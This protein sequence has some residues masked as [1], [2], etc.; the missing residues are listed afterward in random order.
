MKEKQLEEFA[1]ELRREIQGEVLIDPISRLLYSTD[2]SIYQITPLGVV[3]PKS[4]SDID[5]IVELAARHALPILAR[6]SGSSLSGQAVGPAIIVDCSRYLNKII[7]MNPEERTATVEPGVVLAVFNRQ[8]NAFGM[9]FG[10]DPASNDRATF[11]GMIGN[12]STGA[13]SILY[14]MTGDHVLELDLVLADGSS[15][16]AHDNSLAKSKQIAKRNSVEGRLYQTVL[17]IREK[18][19]EDVRVGWPKTW[20]RSTGYSLHYIWSWSPSKPPRWYDPNLPYPPFNRENL[21]L[22]PLIA[23]SE[24]TL[25]VIKS[26]KV[27]IV[28]APR[29]TVLAVLSYPSNYAACSD[30][31]QLLSLNPSAI[32]LIPRALIRLA[33][34]VP[35][36]ARRLGFVKGDPE[37]LLL[38]EFFGE[39]TTDVNDK[40]KAL[41]KDAIV[42]AEPKEQE[43]I[44]EVRK[45]GL[46]LL[47][48]RPGDWK[49]IPFVEDIAVPV[50]RL[51]EFVQAMDDI[52]ADNET[53]GDYYAHASAGCLHVRPLINL[54]TNEGTQRLRSI[55]EAAVVLTQ[56][57]DGA[58]SGEHGDGLARS[59][60]LNWV[61]DK[62]LVKAFRELKFAAD[63]ENVLNPG[64]KVDAE[65][66]DRNLRYGDTY[67]AEAWETKLDFSSQGGFIGAIEMCNGAGVCRKDDG[68]MC[69]TFQV[70]REEN[71]STRGRANLLRALISGR[72]SDESERMEYVKN[73][74]DLCIACKGCKAECPSA[75]DMAKLKSEFLDHYYEMRSRPFKDFVFARIG[76]MTARMRPIAAVLMP[77]VN[78][79][80]FNGIIRTLLGVHTQRAL[81]EVEPVIRSKQR[82]VK[83]KR[84]RA[85]FLPDAYSSV[86]Q[87][88]LLEMLSAIIGQIGCE[89][90]A[91][92]ISGAGRTLIS[93]G[94]LSKARNH[95]R[96]VIGAI[97]ELDPKGELPI[98]G[99]EPS[100]ILTLRDEYLDFF[101][102]DEYVKNLA[103][104]AWT[105]E[106]FIIRPNVD[107]DVR[108]DLLNFD[109]KPD[110]GELSD[111]R[112]RVLLHGHCYQKAQPPSDDGYPSGVSATV[113]MLESAGWRVELIDAGCCG[114]AGSFGYEDEHYEMSMQIAEM[115]LLPAV[116]EAQD[117]DQIAAAGFSCRSQIA[118]GTDRDPVHPLQLIDPSS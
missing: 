61:F 38:V 58:L 52:F 74:L 48:S 68:V 49:P 41:A 47:M 96:A 88:N 7:D 70:T 78:R 83:K 23:G 56:R 81:P 4:Q 44:W 99:I 69:P 3:Y 77:I 75:V 36:Y 105:I 63:P 108:I 37:T 72:L 110:M 94:Y 54:K 60:W 89:L 103:K 79:S 1:F 80:V 98:I 57:M 85:L 118:N 25:G 97:R 109:Q 102:R 87:P 111:Q 115:S 106:E 35:A 66:M 114:M 71:L 21:N 112:Q 28:D 19:W 32:E 24:G 8:A 84:E 15:M 82:A 76:S 95:A 16:L 100:E 104:R 46:G 62:N 51:A 20:R 101:P 9:K 39:D 18:Y 107:G 53:T 22:A 45:V 43:E 86:F 27:R 6:G 67:R 91:I 26:A 17:N 34:E 11:G 5:I 55:A 65:R 30:V 13:H 93:K 10:P 116:R 2:A 92:H 113:T 73:A 64:K 29:K 40:I 90:T 12:N 31:P 59:E 117:T 33:R 14:G 42:V 50:E